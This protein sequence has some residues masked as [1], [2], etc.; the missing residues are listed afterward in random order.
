MTGKSTYALVNRRDGSVCNAQT[1][2]LSV[3]T[4]AANATDNAAGAAAT[5]TVN[6]DS[7]KFFCDAESQI[8]SFEA[9]IDGRLNDLR[10]EGAERRLLTDARAALDDQLPAIQKLGEVLR[11]KTNVCATPPS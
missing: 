3:G 1:F 10:S 4:N 8:T 5:T 7:L 11:D 9:Q 2:I 6:L